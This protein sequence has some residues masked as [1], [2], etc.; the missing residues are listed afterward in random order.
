MI[1]FESRPKSS[2]L[3]KGDET[4]GKA[5]TGTKTAKKLKDTS[6]HNDRLVVF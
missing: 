2:K 1:K 4:R 3:K 5:L 6:F